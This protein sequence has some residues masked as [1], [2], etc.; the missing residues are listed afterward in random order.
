M[1]KPK[2]GLAFRFGRA[3]DLSYSCINR[4]QYNYMFRSNPAQGM[5]YMYVRGK[6][7]F[8]T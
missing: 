6:C 7:D 3:Y 8:T 2:I 1:Q 5:I 4:I